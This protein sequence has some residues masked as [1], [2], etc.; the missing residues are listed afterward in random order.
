MEVFVYIGVAWFFWYLIFGKAKPEKCPSCDGS[1]TIYTQDYDYV[2]KLRYDTSSG[3]SV[4]SGTGRV[5][6]LK[7]KDGVKYYESVEK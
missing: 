6:F 2:R 7:K 5:R 1:G 4:C 3:C